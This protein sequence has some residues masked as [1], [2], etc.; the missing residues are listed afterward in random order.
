MTRVL[1][2]A[3]TVG[4]VWTYALQLAD[5]LAP[6]DVEVHLA[7]M[8]T[9]MSADQRAAAHTSAVA[10][11]HESSFA[12][13]WMP[14]AWDDV[15][16][17]GDWLLTVAEQVAPDV[18]HL[19]GFVHA[20]LPWSSPTV[21]VAHSCVL[22]W[23][24]A[25]HGTDAP[26]EWD[27]Y[28]QRVAA[29]LLAADEVVAPSGAMLAALEECYGFTGGRVVPNSRASDWVRPMAKERLVLGAGRVWDEAKNLAALQR[30]GP[31]LPWPVAIAGAAAVPGAGVLGQLSWPELVQWLL[32]AS[33]YV[34]PAR[35]EPFGLGV[36]EAA[37]AGCALVLGDIPSLHEV[38][39]T[40]ATYVDPDDDE[41]L[42][43]AVTALITDEA[44]R[45][46]MAAKAHRRAAA[47]SPEAMAR[48]Y[49]D[50]YARVPVGAGDVR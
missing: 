16:R 15:D 40:T 50:V 12:L 5:A 45:T 13:E 24:R 19:N 41:G 35:Y 26:A 44:L 34:A 17:A 33:I 30:V 28:R 29:G 18:V 27:T 42:V 22:S 38:W 7:T 23:W 49:L 3:D 47:Y 21:V 11:V 39:D 9:P 2:T 10:D 36:L 1:M 8:G 32:R 31:R 20:A 43:A 4:G 14:D 6:C 46:S 25:V 37:Q 48:G